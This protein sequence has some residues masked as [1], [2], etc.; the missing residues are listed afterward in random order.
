MRN[1]ICT[2]LIVIGYSLFY[3][4]AYACFCKKK[5]PKRMI[6]KKKIKIYDTFFCVLNVFKASEIDTS[7]YFMISFF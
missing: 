1:I 7:G 5:G 6:F 2:Y 3:M 4:Q